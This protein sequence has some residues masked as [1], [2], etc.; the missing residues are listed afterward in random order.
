MI[1][2]MWGHRS[3]KKLMSRHWPSVGDA[4][5]D[6]IIRAVADPACV[7]LRQHLSP[8]SLQMLDPMEEVPEG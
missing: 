2:L 5:P 6:V 8:E 4:D 3:L 7:Y 1:G